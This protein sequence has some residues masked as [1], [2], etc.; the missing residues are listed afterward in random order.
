MSAKKTMNSTVP[1]Q[2]NERHHRDLNSGNEFRDQHQ[3]HQAVEERGDARRGHG[4]PGKSDKP[5]VNH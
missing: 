5:A 2:R 3:A 1:D 4:G